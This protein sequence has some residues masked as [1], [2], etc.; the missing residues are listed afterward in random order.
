[1]RQQRIPSR[2]PLKVAHVIKDHSVRQPLSTTAAAEGGQWPA[3]LKQ[4]MKVR[5]ALEEWK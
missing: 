1:M 2:G 4:L 3:C 5:K